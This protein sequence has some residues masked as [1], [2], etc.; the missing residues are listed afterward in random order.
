MR[1]ALGF[2]E[3]AKINKKKTPVQLYMVKDS[4]KKIDEDITKKVT[5]LD[6]FRTKIILLRTLNLF[7]QWFGITLCYY[8]K[9][10]D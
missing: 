5:V 1:K 10:C 4:K 9:K 3:G 8:G 6:L 7:F 2:D